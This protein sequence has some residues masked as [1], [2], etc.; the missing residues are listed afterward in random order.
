MP[1]VARATADGACPM[2]AAT[3]PVRGPV[4][5]VEPMPAGRGLPPYCGNGCSVQRPI[6]PP[7]AVA[8]VTSL[9]FGPGLE[10][11]WPKITSMM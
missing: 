7:C 11:Q 5:D 4:A 10:P 9:Q 2:E 1:G 3:G 6:V 8:S